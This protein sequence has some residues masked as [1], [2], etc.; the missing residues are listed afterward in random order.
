MVHDP[1]DFLFLIAE[2]IF[3]LAVIVFFKM[4]HDKRI[5]FLICVLT[6]SAFVKIGLF[7]DLYMRGSAVP[8]FALFLLVTHKLLINHNNKALKYLCMLA[9]TLGLSVNMASHI[10]EDKGRNS[11]IVKRGHSHWLVTPSPIYNQYIGLR[12]ESL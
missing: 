6:L 12:K 9:L 1:E 3:I 5:V 10:I 7:N 4:Y 11:R 8:V 2:N